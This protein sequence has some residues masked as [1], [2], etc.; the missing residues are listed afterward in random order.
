MLP[1]E[2]TLQ[3]GHG[4]FLFHGS[5]FLSYLLFQL[6]IFF[7]HDHFKEQ[8]G[9]FEFLPPF[10]PGLNNFLQLAMFFLDQCRCFSIIPEIGG[11]GLPF[12]FIKPVFFGS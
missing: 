11:Q 10:I 7:L 12:Q 1:A 3:L 6:N 8:F 4:Q 9:I 2:H 5:D